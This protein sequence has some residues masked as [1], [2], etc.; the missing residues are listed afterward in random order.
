MNFEQ[1]LELI[2]SPKLRRVLNDETLTDYQKAANIHA[3][4]HAGANEEAP[5]KPRAAKPKPEAEVRETHEE[6]G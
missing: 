3:W 5:R 4:L 6:I 1:V 2:T